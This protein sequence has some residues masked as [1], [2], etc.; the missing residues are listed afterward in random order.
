MEEPLG[1]ARKHTAGGT[2]VLHDY[3]HLSLPYA[4]PPEWKRCRLPSIA[5][6][7]RQAHSIDLMHFKQ[8]GSQGTGEPQLAAG[9][10]VHVV[11]GLSPTLLHARGRLFNRVALRALGKPSC[12]ILAEEHLPCGECIR[13]LVAAKP[14]ATS[15]CLAAARTEQYVHLLTHRRD[16]GKLRKEASLTY[17][18]Q[19]LSVAFNPSIRAEMACLLSTCQLEAYHLDHL[20]LS[21]QEPTPSVIQRI[22]ISESSPAPPESAQLEFGCHPRTLFVSTDAQLRLADLREGHSPSQQ[23]LLFDASHSPLE[24]GKLTSLAICREVGSPH[25]AVCSAEHL[26]LLDTRS[27]RLPVLQ[28]RLPIPVRPQRRTVTSYNF[29]EFGAS[30]CIHLIDSFSATCLAFDYRASEMLPSLPP[31]AP[32][33]PVSLDPDSSLL[34]LLTRASISSGYTSF[35]IAGATTFNN[36][37]ETSGKRDNCSLDLVVLSAVGELHRLSCVG[38]DSTSTRELLG[39]PTA[40]DNEAAITGCR[41]VSSNTTRHLLGLMATNANADQVSGSEGAATPEA[42]SAQELDT[43]S[44][45]DTLLPELLTQWTSWQETVTPNEGGEPIMASQSVLRSGMRTVQSASLLHEGTRGGTLS[46]ESPSHRLSAGEPSSLHGTTRTQ[47]AR[48]PSVGNTLP[49]TSSAPHPKKRHASAMLPPP[50]SSS[51][52]GVTPFAGWDAPQRGAQRS[53]RKSAGF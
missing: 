23:R 6:S 34:E 45:D 38:K 10:R 2:P 17:D 35:P 26:M 33:L 31:T 46:S 27:M 51:V 13:Q 20:P 28:W 40:V 29:V 4:P 49:I 21:G 44:V 50:I 9:N 7:H 36:K 15:F 30:E 16:P 48:T 32:P 14:S 8:P 39:L 12:P 53:R 24:Y 52:A 3:A 37:L 42:S 47:V 25:L 22:S 43:T 41:Q 5:L 11:R 1:A 18:G 19:P